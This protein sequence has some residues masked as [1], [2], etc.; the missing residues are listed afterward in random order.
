VPPTSFQ[1]NMCFRWPV[2]LADAG[3]GEDY[4]TSATSPWIARGGRVSIVRAGV[5]H[6]DGYLDATGC[7]GP[8]TAA[9]TTGFSIFGYSRARIAGN[10][11]IVRDAA[12]KTRSFVIWQANPGPNQNPVFVFPEVEAVSTLLAVSAYTLQKFHGGMTGKTIPVENRCR[13]D[14]SACCNCSS[15]DSIWVTSADRKFLIAHEMGHRVL[16]LFAGGFNNDTSFDLIPGNT[17]GTCD[18]TS[19]HSM[20]SM[21]LESGAAMEGW[22][23]FIAVATFNS[24][25]GTNPGAFLRY[26]DSAE[27]TV[28]VEQGDVGGASSY[29]ATVCPTV[30]SAIRLGVQLDWLRHWWDYY[31]NAT[32]M[33]PGYAPTV[34]RMMSEID[35]APAWS[36]GTAWSSIRAGVKT[37]SGETQQARWDQHGAWNGID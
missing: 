36:P 10:D 3:F 32:D 22:A 13:P 15:G 5:T 18:T 20:W 14:G 12:G 23:H 24:R 11:L 6:F 19:A 25:A 2:S 27:T 9:G 17:S 21:E 37:Y 4:G 28:D 30:A 26:W 8:F 31:S 29:F 33:D 1:F 34:T 7:T 16:G 35:A